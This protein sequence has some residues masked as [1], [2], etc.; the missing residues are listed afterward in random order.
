MNPFWPAAAGSATL[1][2]AKPCNLNVVP[3]T[4]L[5]SNM[6]SRA[7]NSAQD[8]GHSLAMF[9]GHVGKEKSSQ[10]ATMEN[11]QRK[12]MLLQQALPAGAP[13][14]ILV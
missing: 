8:K 13:S 12:Q 9:P 5:Q 10:A 11:A 2:G 3:S 7:V 14:N 4:E 1:Y 6:V